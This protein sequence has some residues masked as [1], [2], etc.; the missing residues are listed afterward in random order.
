M[1]NAAG[2]TSYSALN[3]AQKEGAA[4]RNMTFVD[5]PEILHVTPVIG[6]PIKSPKVWPSTGDI[7][8]GYQLHGPKVIPCRDMLLMGKKAA[9][10]EV[11]TNPIRKLE[12]F[13]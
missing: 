13:R 6:V 11:Y 7:F 2:K 8:M 12:S 3:T 9:T 10:N 5:V 4:E 1:V